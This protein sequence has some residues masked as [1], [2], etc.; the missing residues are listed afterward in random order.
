M[1]F[2]LS[3]VNDGIDDVGYFP[4]DRTCSTA[5]RSSALRARLTTDG[6]LST[7]MDGG[8]IAVAGSSTVYPLTQRMAARF[9]EAGF[10]GDITVEAR[11]QG[12]F[13]AL[14]ADRTIDVANASHT[15]S[16]QETAACQKTRRTPVEARVGTDAAAVVVSSENDSHRCDAWPSCRPSSPAPRWSGWNPAW[17]RRAHRALH[18]EPG[19]HLRLLLWNRS[20]PT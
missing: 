12:G 8:T 20:T 14:C 6:D 9:M 13:V 3:H 15:I 18:A 1:D 10:Q 17:P 7:A 4:A 19:R 11:A 2:Y 5:P 16:R